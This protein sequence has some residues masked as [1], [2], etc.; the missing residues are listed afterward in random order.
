ML[1][2]SLMV[3]WRRK[4]GCFTVWGRTWFVLCEHGI[5]LWDPDPGRHLR[6]LQVDS[7]YF[8]DGLVLLCDLWG[9]TALSS[10]FM[11]ATDSQGQASPRKRTAAVGQKGNLH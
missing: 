4:Y 8:M 5:R 2:S 9:Q 7:V 6:N 1:T 11:P 10:C 3:A